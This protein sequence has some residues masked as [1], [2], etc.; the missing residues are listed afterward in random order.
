MPKDVPNSEGNDIG[1]LIKATTGDRGRPR[2]SLT[3]GKLIDNKMRP[4]IDLVLQVW[5][6]DDGEA[7]DFLGELRLKGDALLEMAKSHQKMV[8]L[9]AM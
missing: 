9:V 1:E 5:D 2:A 7:S 4:S 3:G 6:E 8:R